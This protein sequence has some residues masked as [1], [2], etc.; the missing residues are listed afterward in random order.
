LCCELRNF[1][2]D[3]A[4]LPLGSLMFAEAARAFDPGLVGIPSNAL[5]SIAI[6]KN[7][8]AFPP[9]GFPNHEPPGPD[10][11]QAGTEQRLVFAL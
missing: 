1:A 3:D 11:I 2:V 6:V 8:V 9:A 5:F 10:T 7:G 4:L